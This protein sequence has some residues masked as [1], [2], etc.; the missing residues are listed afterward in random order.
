M[1]NRSL[2]GS[3][4]QDL[5]DKSRCDVL[6]IWNE[7]TRLPCWHECTILYRTYV[8][9]HLI[10]WFETRLL[11]VKFYVRLKQQILPLERVQKRAL[12]IILGPMYLTYAASLSLKFLNCPPLTI[13]RR[14]SLCLTFAQGLVKDNRLSHLIPQPK[15]TRRVLRN[16]G[17]RRQQIQCKTE[18]LCTSAI[19]YLTELLNEKNL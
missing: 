7:T 17:V 6:E 11:C 16:A 13:E 3:L 1:I 4:N 12:R 8:Y 10:G 18:R 15:E 9:A 14:K 5:I 19:P 2:H